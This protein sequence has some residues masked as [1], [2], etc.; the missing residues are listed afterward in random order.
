MLVESIKSKVTFRSKAA[1]ITNRSRAIRNQARAFRTVID[2]SNLLGTQDGLEGLT[3]HLISSV[4]DPTDRLSRAFAVLELDTSASDSEVDAAAA[5][6]L[7]TFH[8]KENRGS[9]RK[10]AE[11][12]ACFGIIRSREAEKAYR[13]LGIN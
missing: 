9:I 8:P 13:V 11:V 10:F 12:I 1:E 6:L 2:V 4:F 7:G 5:R 3:E